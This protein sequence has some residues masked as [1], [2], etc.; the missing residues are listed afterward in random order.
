MVVKDIN[1]LDEFGVL[2]NGR[3]FHPVLMSFQ[4]SSRWCT[5]KIKLRHGIMEGQM[6]VFAIF[7]LIAFGT[8]V[9]LGSNAGDDHFQNGRWLC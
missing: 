2:T 3:S 4:V 7:T 6:I 8:I 1:L 9:Y 5:H